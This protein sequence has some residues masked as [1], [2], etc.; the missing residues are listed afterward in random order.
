MSFVAI[1][2]SNL[3]HHTKSSMPWLLMYKK[4]QP[5]ARSLLLDH[6]APHFL[7]VIWKSARARHFPVLT[8]VIGSLMVI[9][10]TVASTGLFSLQSTEIQRGIP[11]TRYPSFNTASLDLSSID[12]RPVLIVSSILSGNLSIAYPA[13]T[14]EQFVVGSLSP[15]REMSC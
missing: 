14:N 9:A 12:A 2:W 15:E 10:T 7:V 3:E 6:I 13:N 4:P 1:Y 11:M 8:A 5:A